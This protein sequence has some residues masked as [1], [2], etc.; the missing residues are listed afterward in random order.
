MKMLICPRCSC[1]FKILEGKDLQQQAAMKVGCTAILKS[2]KQA[3]ILNT[4]DDI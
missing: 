4:N 1:I 3:F 2:F